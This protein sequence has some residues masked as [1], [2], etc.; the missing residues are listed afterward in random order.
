MNQPPQTDKRIVSKGAYVK[1][2]GKR[3][4]LI[5]AAGC[6]CFWGVHVFW[7]TAPYTRHP[8]NHAHHIFAG[9]LGFLVFRFCWS[10]SKGLYKEVKRIEPGVPLTR[11]N[12]A[13]LPAPDSL[14]RASAEP[15][16]EQQA[17]LLRAATAGV[18]RHEEQLVRAA[19][20]PE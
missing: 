15:L 18:E 16:Q 14:V 12:I 3:L 10:I 11:A 2:Q 13:A 17:V 19:G 6:V 7:N 4:G 1:A 8:A 9:L 5:V 20:E